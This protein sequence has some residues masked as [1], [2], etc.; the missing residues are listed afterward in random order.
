MSCKVDDC[1]R[2]VHALG[3]CNSHYE[4]DR[5]SRIFKPCEKEGCE[6]NQHGHGLCSMHYQRWRNANRGKTCELEYCEAMLWAAG[7][8]RGHYK[9]KQR[10]APFSPLQDRKGRTRPC[11]HDG[12]DGVPVARGYCNMHYLHFRVNGVTLDRARSA[13]SRKYLSD[14]LEKGLWE[15]AH[16]GRIASTDDFGKS[17]SSVPVS[18]C[19]PC[20][21]LVLRLRR[22][23]L[24]E[25]SYAALLEL[26]ANACAVCGT[27]EPDMG[28][29]HIDHDHS[30]CGVGVYPTCGKCVR[31]LLCSNCNTRGVAWYERLP[32][33]LRQF[34]LLND[35]L[36]SPPFEQVRV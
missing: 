23:Q 31:G 5:K 35:Y 13:R 29:W 21:A 1:E 19:R 12:C 20:A 2:E 24:S 9:Q 15:C 17:A 16:C 7:L 4:K 36:N 18:Y 11:K 33:E 27:E 10:G 3:M 34:P 8:C 6:G 22:F 26:Q 14:L 25:E 28:E 32:E 30:C